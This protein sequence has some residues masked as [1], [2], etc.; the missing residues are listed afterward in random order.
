VSNPDA[1]YPTLQRGILLRESDRPQEAVAF[2]QA[3]IAIRPDSAQAY[4]ELARCWAEIPLERANAI[5]AIDRAISLEPTESYYF[6]LKGW[7][8]VCLDKYNPA[9]LAAYQGLGL[10]PTCRQ[11]LNALANA[12]TKLGQWKRAET[13]CLHILELDSDDTAAL[14]LLA[15]ALRHQGRWKESRV[16]VNQLLA[17]LPND[18]FGQANAGYGALAAGDHL[19]ANE[20]FREAL[21]MAPDFDYARR[22]LLASLR[23]R[24]WVVRWNM[25]MANS[26]SRPATA[27]DI[28]WIMLAF[29][30]VI[31]LGIKCAELLNDYHPRSGTLLFGGLFALVLAYV[32]CSALIYLLGDFFLLFDPFGR[33]AMTRDEKIKVCI[34]GMTLIV[35]IGMV[36]SK[37]GWGIGL[38]L[39]LFMAVLIFSIRYPLMK[40]RWMLRR[41]SRNAG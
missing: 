28:L 2:I 22:G 26:I 40:D 38:C 21:R 6:G 3:A 36:F 12:H 9:I 31:W 37:G 27:R 18:A 34:P 30:F 39:S 15:Q 17:Q 11:S 7:L 20:H 14:N 13:V 4:A 33:H 32:G 10:S 8:Y 25:R 16:V 41:Q 35:I 29:A 5:G 24:I 23:A 19:R 1:F